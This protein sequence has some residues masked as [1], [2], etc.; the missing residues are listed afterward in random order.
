MAT[1]L[2]VYLIG[3]L[4]PGIGR[5]WVISNTYRK[6]TLCVHNCEVVVNVIGEVDVLGV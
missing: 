1:I 3:E 4:F 6:V 2:N 5:V